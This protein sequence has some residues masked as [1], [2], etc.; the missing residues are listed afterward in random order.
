MIDRYCWYKT[1]LNNDVKEISLKSL[2][3]LPEISCFNHKLTALKCC[4]LNE[5]ERIKIIIILI[6]VRVMTVEH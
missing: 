4:E 1:F 5:L 3:E 2:L 6:S